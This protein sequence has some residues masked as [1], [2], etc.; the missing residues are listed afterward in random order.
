[1]KKVAELIGTDLDHAVAIAKGGFIFDVFY[2]RVWYMWHA[3]HGSLSPYHTHSVEWSPSTDW[4]YGGP[5][6]ETS[7]ISV[8]TE[9]TKD[10]HIYWSAYLRNNLFLEDGSDC[11]Q[12]GPTMLIAAM[13]T[14]VFYRVGE[15]I[16][17]TTNEGE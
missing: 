9:T 2:G 14:F 8:Q 15:F 12:T 5:I 7:G 17:L 11:F 16:D 10:G 1:M 3:T 4:L 6:I 13:R